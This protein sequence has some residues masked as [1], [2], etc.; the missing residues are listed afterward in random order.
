MVLSGL[1][2]DLLRVWTVDWWR[3]ADAEVER[4]DVA[5]RERLAADPGPGTAL[6]VPEV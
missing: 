5:L 2:W 3:D 4:L 6:S 1:G